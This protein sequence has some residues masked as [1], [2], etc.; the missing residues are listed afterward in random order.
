M[1]HQIDPYVL[2]EL[3]QTGLVRY[4]GFVFEEFL[5]E[6]QGPKGMAKY[7]EMRDNDPTIGAALFAF[8]QLVRK[9]GWRVEPFSQDA[10]DV[11]RG[12]F[13]HGCMDD[14]SS[15]WSDTMSE[16][17]SMVPF[18]WAWHEIVYKHRLGREPGVDEA[19]NPLPISKYDDGLVGWRRMPIRAQESLWS[20]KFASSGSVQAMVQRPAPSFQTIE[21]PIEKSLLFRHRA[22]KNNPEGRSALRNAYRPWFFKSKLEVIEAIGVERD[23]AGLPMAQ[24]P[25]ELLSANASDEEKAI[26]AEVK[27]IVSNVRNDEQGGIVW[28]LAYDD[29]GNELYKFSLLSTG[30]RRAIDT[31]ALV[32]R[33]DEKIAQTLLADLIL[34]GSSGGHGS[35]SMMETKLELFTD[36]IEGWLDSI[37]EVLNRYAVPRL[38]KMNGWPADRMP[39]IAHGAVKAADVEALGAFIASVADRGFLSPK[40]GDEAY[41]RELVSMPAP[42]EEEADAP[43]EAPLT[44]GT[45]KGAGPTV[46]HVHQ[47]GGGRWSRQDVEAMGRELVKRISRQGGR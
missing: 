36:A 42:P 39:T 6:L 28:P 5:R 13:L 20:W 24:V 8:D 40:P 35:Y 9:T 29:D 21:I 37:A 18:G 34:I 43:P 32:Q 45:E 2:Q 27:R 4:G 31:N 3:G 33:Y 47:G 1:D 17:M 44:Q 15:T 14:M 10:Q 38:W 23:L 16:A 41:L 26:L 7:R 11:Q 12:E 19:G 25:P 30:G 46:V 22:Y